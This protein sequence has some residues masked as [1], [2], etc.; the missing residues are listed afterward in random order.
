MSRT[1]DIR[2]NNATDELLSGGMGA[3]AYNRVEVRADGSIAAGAGTA[4]PSTVLRPGGGVWAFPFPSVAGTVTDAAVTALMG[5][6]PANGWVVINSTTDQ[7]YYRKAGVW[8]QLSLQP[9]APGAPVIGT[10]TAGNTT[11]TANWTAP[12]TGSA[13]TSYTVKTYKASDNSLLFTDVVGNVLTFDR[14][15]LTNGVGV[16][17][18][19]DPTNIAG[20]GPQSA[21]SNTVTPAAISTAFITSGV[22]GSGLRSDATG[23]FGFKFTVGASDITVTH[24]GRWVV[25]GNSQTHNVKLYSGTAN[26]SELAAVVV[27]CAG[28]PTGAYKYVALGSPIV[29]TAGTTYWLGSEEASGGDQ[30]YDDAICT[31]TAVATI[32]TSIYALPASAAW[33]DGNAGVHNIT[34]VSFKYA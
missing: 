32:T 16:Y 23:K 24:L 28:A 20:T 25:A 30:W 34:P 2:R 31:T 14:G 3:D 27:D 22:P 10:A 26:A 13:V 5:V 15:G 1:N 6:A 33:N 21:A 11:A 8:T 17:F 9:I 19:V 29:L 4:S 18:K 12:T 7:L